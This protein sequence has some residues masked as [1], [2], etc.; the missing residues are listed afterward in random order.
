M[1][2]VNGKELEDGD[3]IDIHQTVNGQ[4]LFV[5]VSCFPVL[6]IRYGHD[7]SYKYQYDMQSLLSPCQY[8][9]EVDWEIVG[10][11]DSHILRQ[12]GQPKVEE[13]TIDADSIITRI[14]KESVW[15]ERP[16]GVTVYKP[17][18]LIE[19]LVRVLCEE[20]GKLSKGESCG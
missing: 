13:K 9:G 15:Y 1:K 14:K 5:V 16:D 8:S 3:I 19:N 7:L 2:D 12:V 11:L 17:M 20:I 18:L 6:D 10:K 4:N